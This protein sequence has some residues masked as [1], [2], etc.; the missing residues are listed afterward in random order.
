[1]PTA[2]NFI[3]MR[4]EFSTAVLKTA[5]VF[6][7]YLTHPVEFIASDYPI[8]PIFARGKWESGPRQFTHLAR[9]PLRKGDQ[10]GN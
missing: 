7:H 4:T 5:D 6:A 2:T 8:H 10:V 9:Y 3:L 1:M